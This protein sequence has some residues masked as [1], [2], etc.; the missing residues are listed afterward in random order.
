MNDS[1][2]L[3]I[4]RT[5]THIYGVKKN[6][7]NHLSKGCRLCPKTEKKHVVVTLIYS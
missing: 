3:E 7:S 5:L 4:Q 6:D 2:T 1:K